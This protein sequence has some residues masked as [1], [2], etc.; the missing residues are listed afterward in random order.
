MNLF[1]PHMPVSQKIFAHKPRDLQYIQRSPLYWHVDFFDH[2][3]RNYLIHLTTK[4]ECSCLHLCINNNTIKIEIHIKAWHCMFTHI[5]ICSK[6][7]YQLKQSHMKTKQTNWKHAKEM[8]VLNGSR[9][10]Q[11]R[12][13]ILSTSKYQM[14]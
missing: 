13:I 14:T 1:T 10:W 12:I 4:T 3:N 7:T 11:T 6:I 8:F 5:H 2:L 9:I